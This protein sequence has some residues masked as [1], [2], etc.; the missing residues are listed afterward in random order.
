MVGQEEKIKQ[1]LLGFTG[2][3]GDIFGRG[4]GYTQLREAINAA[5][6]GE[7]AQALEMILRLLQ[8]QMAG[9]GG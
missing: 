8:T 1:D 2:A 3:A 9:W 5:R 6:R 4:M 7:G